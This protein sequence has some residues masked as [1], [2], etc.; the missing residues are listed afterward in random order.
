MGRNVGN[1][2]Q[3]SAEE[4]DPCSI[5][6]RNRICIEDTYAMGVQIPDGVYFQVLM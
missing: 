2:F 6:L 4:Q 1:Q 5:V 3:S